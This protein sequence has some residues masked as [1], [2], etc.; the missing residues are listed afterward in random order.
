MRSNNSETVQK[1][2]F[3]FEILPPWYRTY[4]AYALYILLIY[5]VAYW[6]VRVIKIKVH[7][8]KIRE[9]RKKDAEMKEKER[10]FLLDSHEKEMEMLEL[11][12]ENMKFKLKSK[13]QEL[14]NILLNQVNKKELLQDIKSDLKSLQATLKEKD[15]EVCNRKMVVL[16][17]KISKSIEQEIDWTK[18][19]DNFDIVNDY[20]LQR[21]TEK[22]P[23]LNKNE[24]KLCIYIKMGMITKEIAP[25]MNLSIRGVEMMRYRMRKKMGLERA[26]DIEIYFQTFNNSLISVVK[27]IESVNEAVENEIED[28]NFETKNFNNQQFN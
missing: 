24:R 14:S 25:L 18:F 15:F 5:G 11:K 21:L 9:L 19:E 4:P 3:D 23:W 7:R 13:S 26:D 10:Q 27:N 20:F 12:N 28:S 1:T 6:T 2:E 16:Q 17:G 8:A 22:F